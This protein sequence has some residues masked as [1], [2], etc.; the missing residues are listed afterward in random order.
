MNQVRTYRPDNYTTVSNVPI[1]QFK[2]VVAIGMLTYLCSHKDGFTIT[3]TFLQNRFGRAAAVNSLNYLEEQGYLLSFKIRTG[4]KNGHIYYV[5][6]VKFDEATVRMLARRIM[7]EEGINYI[8]ELNGLYQYVIEEDEFNEKSSTVENRQLKKPHDTND[9][10]TV[11]NQQ[12]NTNNGKATVQ[13]QPQK[14]TKDLKEKELKKTNSQKT[15]TSSSPSKTEESVSRETLRRGLIDKHGQASVE[16]IERDL[17]QDPSVSIVT[18]KQYIAL[19]TYRLKHRFKK[20]S[21][22]PNPEWLAEEKRK[23]RAF[24]QE[25]AEKLLKETEEMSEEELARLVAELS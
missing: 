5:S 6:D 21:N 8:M 22:G 7:Q 13:N 15:K 19:M 11:E 2:S 23:Q 14:K 12:L 3:K 25:Q 4:P 9:S 17:E 20:P 1:R 24:E 16:E 10:S 18:D